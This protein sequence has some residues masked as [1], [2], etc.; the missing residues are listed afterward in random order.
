MNRIDTPELAR[1]ENAIDHPER[2]STQFRCGARRA[3][4]VRASDPSVSAFAASMPGPLEI[5]ALRECAFAFSGSLEPCSG[6]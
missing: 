5:G 3:E 6:H 1:F 4:G 2:F